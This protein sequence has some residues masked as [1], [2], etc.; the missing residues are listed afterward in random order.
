MP[1]RVKLVEDSDYFANHSQLEFVDSGCEVL[2]CTLGGGWVLGR[3]ANIVGDFSSGKT[4]LAIE[5]S[6]N[7]HRQY[8]NGNIYYREAEAAFDEGYASALGMPIDVVKFIEPEDFVTVEDFY[9]DLCKCVEECKKKNIPGIYFVDSM[10]ALSDK[11]ELGQKFDEGTYGTS[12][13][14][15]LGK[16]FRLCK[17][18]ISEAR[19]ALIIIFQTRDKIGSQFVKKTHSGGNAPDF[20][21]SQVLWLSHADDVTRTINKV[22]RIVGIRIKAKCTKNKI[23]IPYRQ[24]EFTIRFGHG[25]D[26]LSSSLDW[27][28]DVYRFEETVGCTRE[29]FKK[30]LAGMND[31][32][33]W[34]ESRH[35]DNVVNSIWREIEQSF[36][37]QPR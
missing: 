13:S 36:L 5:A 21:A 15:Q 34:S 25:I 14:K 30:R 35:V 33:Y 27:L 12:K 10:D 17:A 32:E 29:T 9:S 2:N 7:F 26:S 24:C 19:V 4:L 22:K 3:I 37:E 8:P 18:K 6:A 11:V 16:L 28:E 1:S 31:D 23:S 20:Y